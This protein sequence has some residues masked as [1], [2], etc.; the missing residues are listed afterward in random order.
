MSSD[1]KCSKG[2]Y[3]A[4]KLCSFVAGACKKRETMWGKSINVQEMNFKRFE[5]EQRKEKCDRYQ[6]L[7]SDCW[8]EAI[9]RTQG[10]D[11]R[12]EFKP[13]PLKGE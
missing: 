12:P 11:G 8:W 5:S 2:I 7:T 6:E 10:N 9:Q 13:Q 1:R 4:L 3:L